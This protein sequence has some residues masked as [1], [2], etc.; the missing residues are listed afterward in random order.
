MKNLGVVLFIFFA[1]TVLQSEA[2]AN[3]FSKYLGSWAYECNEAPYPYHE[4]DLLI[5]EKDKK[6][7]VKVTFKDGRSIT[8]QNVTIKDDKLS[9]EI[10]VEGGTVSAVLEQKDKKIIGKVDS[11][12]G[13]MTVSAQKKVVKK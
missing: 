7:T 3:D 2:K 13:K 11:P 10:W 6:T 4:G 8:A 12:E 5:A 9:F 1:V